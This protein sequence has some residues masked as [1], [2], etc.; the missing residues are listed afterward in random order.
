VSG[1]ELY[2][3]A[4]D[5][6]SNTDSMRV[7]RWF[8]AVAFLDPALVS[9]SEQGEALI[10]GGEGVNSTLSSSELFVPASTS[11]S[12]ASTASATSAPA[13]TPAAMQQE[14]AQ[15]LDAVHQQFRTGTKPGVL[16]H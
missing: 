7:A 8:A 15:M 3:P 1:A 2:D 4:S 11:T 13:L 10:T 5:K 9:G 16:G 6:F 14:V 12:T